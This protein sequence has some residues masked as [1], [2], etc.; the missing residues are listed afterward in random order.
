MAVNDPWADRGTG[1][2]CA[3]PGFILLRLV[4]FFFLPWSNEEEIDADDQAGAGRDD[5]EN[6]VH[7]TS[8]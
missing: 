6:N 1:V 3:I 2:P 7:E 4:R 5:P 8:P